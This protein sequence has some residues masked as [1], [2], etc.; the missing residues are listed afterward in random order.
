MSLGFNQS[1][2]GWVWAEKG[3]FSLI[4]VF[5]CDFDVRVER[6]T[7]SHLVCRRLSGSFDPMGD[8]PSPSYMMRGIF[9]GHGPSFFLHL[10]WDGSNWIGLDR[11]LRRSS[12]VALSMLSA[13]LAHLPLIQSCF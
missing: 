3:G 9:D 4:R 13:R 10:I 2:H 5:R 8:A 1:K 7:Y 12:R 11:K 6:L